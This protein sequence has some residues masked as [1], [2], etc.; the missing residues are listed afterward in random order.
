MYFNVKSKKDTLHCLEMIVYVSHICITVQN[1]S[2]GVL[3]Y[4]Q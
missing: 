3:F 1:D 4:V 2:Y